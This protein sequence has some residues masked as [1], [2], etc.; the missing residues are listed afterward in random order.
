[1]PDVRHDGREC[2]DLGGADVG[3]CP[4]LPSVLT[5]CTSPH[6]RKVISSMG[7]GFLVLEA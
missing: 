1:M 5:S 4:S 6:A 7:F 2:A 3:Y